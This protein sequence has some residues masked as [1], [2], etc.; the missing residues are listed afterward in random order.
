MLAGWDNKQQLQPL[1]KRIED[2]TSALER[3]LSSLRFLEQKSQ[4]S[5]SKAP[6]TKQTTDASLSSGGLWFPLLIAFVLG[7]CF[8]AAFQSWPR[9]RL[10]FRKA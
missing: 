4:G 6:L 8:G 1:L 7:C 3:T 10:S 5:P 9:T 2:N